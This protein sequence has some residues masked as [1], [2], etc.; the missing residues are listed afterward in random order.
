MYK[1]PQ[2]HGEVAV[3]EMK[4]EQG[5]FKRV[6]EGVVGGFLIG[7]VGYV[8]VLA[9]ITGVGKFV[10]I[11]PMLHTVATYVGCAGALGVG[12]GWMNARVQERIAGPVSQQRRWLLYSVTIVGSF[13][14][15]ALSVWFYAQVWFEIYIFELFI[16]WV[17]ITLSAAVCGRITSLLQQRIVTLED[18]FR[19]P[20]L[21]GSV[22]G[23]IIGYSVIG[24]VVLILM[25]VANNPEELVM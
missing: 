22:R 6:F 9:L 4:D 15:A 7:M 16:E 13:A 1:V 23:W 5:V 11:A 20:W 2:E 17:G 8:L 12:L 10:S 14:A 25:F 24:G 18:P 3:V 19:R 21:S